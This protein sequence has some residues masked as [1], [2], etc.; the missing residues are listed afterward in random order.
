MPATGSAIKQARLRMWFIFQIVHG[1]YGS[2]FAEGNRGLQS[3]VCQSGA[4]SEWGHVRFRET[5]RDGAAGGAV[6]RSGDRYQLLPIA[7]AAA[8]S[9]RWRPVGLGIMGLQDVFFQLKIGFD[10]EAARALSV[11]IQEEIY[12]HALS[13][14]CDLAEILGSH[15]TFP[16]TRGSGGFAVRWMGY[17]A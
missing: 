14:S 3:G 13:T 17:H 15:E 9:R 7:A 5:G 10:S 12:Y 8:S 1:D 11:R 2:H 6:S 16:E 4:A